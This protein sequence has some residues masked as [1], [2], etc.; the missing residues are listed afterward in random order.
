MAP[1]NKYLAN[2]RLIKES[3]NVFY[4]SNDKRLFPEAVIGESS[5]SHQSIEVERERLIFD[6]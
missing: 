2:R 5:I 1:Q 6:L 3:L 4:A